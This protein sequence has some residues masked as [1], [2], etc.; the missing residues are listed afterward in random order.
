[1]Q[2]HIFGLLLFQAV[3]FGCSEAGKTS[4]KDTQHTHMSGR[5]VCSRTKESFKYYPV[6]RTLCIPKFITFLRPCTDRWGKKTKGM[7]TA[8]RQKYTK[9]IKTFYQK[10]KES[11][12]EFSC[13]A[14]WK[15]VPGKKGCTQPTCKGNC[16]GNGLCTGPNKC[17][18]TPGWQGP[19]CQTDINEC[20][21]NN[22]KCQQKCIN[23]RGTFKCQCDPGYILQKDGR[24]CKFCI[25]CSEEYQQLEKRMT[26][27]EKE[28]STLKTENKKLKS[29]INHI[30]TTLQKQQDEIMVNALEHQNQLK[31]I[32]KIQEKMKEDHE[33]QQSEQKPTQPAPYSPEPIKG[34]QETVPDKSSNEASLKVF[35]QGNVQEGLSAEDNEETKEEDEEEKKKDEKKEM[36]DKEMMEEAKKFM[37]QSPATYLIFNKLVEKLDMLEKRINKC[38]CATIAAQTNDIYSN[39]TSDLDSY[40]TY[41]NSQKK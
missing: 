16:N 23:Y 4:K 31:S 41:D 5:H 22:G 38:S 12:V 24:S 40:Y 2:F 35:D 37:A 33:Q 36:G 3:C 7:C 9:V 14:G 32:S 18:C 27:V 25:K 39:N 15:K 19:S 6:E 8:Y 11:K 29:E 21:K 17:A 13:C 26:N 20:L 10:H 1:M 28:T 34:Q 30:D